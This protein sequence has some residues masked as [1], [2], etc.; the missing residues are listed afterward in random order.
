M[1]KIAHVREVAALRGLPSEVVDVIRDAVIIL[2]TEYGE[3]RDVD[4]GDGGYVMVLD[5]EDE[6]ERLKDI[7]IDVKIAIPEYMDK[8]QCSDGRIFTSTL[9]LLSDDF[10]I[11]VVAP[12]ELLRY[13]NWMAYLHSNEHVE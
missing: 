1:M 6:L 11:I 2:D 5:S 10:S 12:L 13:K 7:H 9:V 8:I 4:R 3:H